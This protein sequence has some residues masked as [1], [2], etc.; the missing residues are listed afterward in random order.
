LSGLDTLSTSLFFCVRAPLLMCPSA[1]VFCLR[2]RSQARARYVV[3]V[4]S[5]FLT[6]Q[7]VD[8]ARECLSCECVPAAFLGRPFDLVKCTA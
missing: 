5:G 6:V 1:F 7:G 4:W 2:I 3:L 8:G